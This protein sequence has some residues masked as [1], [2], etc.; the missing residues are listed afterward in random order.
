MEKPQRFDRK[1]VFENGREFLGAGFGSPREALC[2]CSFDTAMI[3]Y[4]P[5]M[6][7]CLISGLEAA[8]EGMEL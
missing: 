5:L 7:S 3:G 2:Q 6:Y 8:W 1:L 4:Q